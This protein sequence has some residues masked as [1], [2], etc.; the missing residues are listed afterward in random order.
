MEINNCIKIKL[1]DQMSQRNKHILA[2]YLIS[3]SVYFYFFFLFNAF[4]FLFPAQLNAF[5]L[6]IASVYCA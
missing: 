6:F 4:N 1:C 2:F 3:V 5:I